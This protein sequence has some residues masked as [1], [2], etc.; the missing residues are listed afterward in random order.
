MIAVDI[1]VK[2]GILKS[3][4]RERLYKLLDS[5]KLLKNTKISVEQ[6]KHYL[7]QDKKKSG[8]TINFVLLEKTGNAIVKTFSIE[9][10]INYY[11][12]ITR[13]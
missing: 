2:N 4:E 12:L 3:S 13:I 5:F 10:L 7:S 9:E 11:S 6:M 1:S 8:E